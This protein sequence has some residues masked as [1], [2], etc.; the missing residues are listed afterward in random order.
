MEEG[1]QSQDRQIPSEAIEYTLRGQQEEKNLWG[2]EAV[3]LNS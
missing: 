2:G 3:N 1:L